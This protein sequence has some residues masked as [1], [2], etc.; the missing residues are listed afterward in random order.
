MG[1]AAGIQSGRSRSRHGREGGEYEELPSVVAGGAGPVLARRREEEW[2]SGREG[3]ALATGW[4]IFLASLGCRSAGSASR[5]S[6]PRASRAEPRAPYSVIFQHQA[7]PRLG[8]ISANLS[9]PSHEPARLG[10][11][12]PLRRAVRALIRFN[13]I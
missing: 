13:R 5:S 4:G 6:E 8:S 12:P 3:E 9:E 10:S 11:I 1:D 7:E 2:G